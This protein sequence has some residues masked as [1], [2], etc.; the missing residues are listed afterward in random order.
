MANIPDKPP[1]QLGPP[2]QLELKAFTLLE[3]SEKVKR[4][5]E[6]LGWSADGVVEVSLFSPFAAAKAV[7]EQTEFD[8]IL[9]SFD[10]DAKIR[11]VRAVREATGLGLGEAK[12]MLEAAPKAIK[13]GVSRADAEV[14][15]EQ[16]EQAGANVYI[17]R[18]NEELSAKYNPQQVDYSMINQ[19]DDIFFELAQIDHCISRSQV[20]IDELKTETREML[21][22]LRVSIF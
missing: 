11:V 3:A 17:S 10:A 1:Q 12:A 21:S 19:I 6:I 20:S 4:I 5:E 8:V 22:I 15:K 14:V 13:E 9:E 2:G 7:G 16:L 18:K